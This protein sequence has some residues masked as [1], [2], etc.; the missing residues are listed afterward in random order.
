MLDARRPDDAAVTLL[1]GF[2]VTGDTSLRVRA[3]D[4]Y[5]SGLDQGGCAVRSGPAGPVLDQDCAIVRRHICAAS[6]EA[7][8]IYDSAGRVELAERARQSARQEF[9]CAGL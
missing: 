1:A 3:M 4:L 6:I 5:R 2:M 8:E 9:H 7:I